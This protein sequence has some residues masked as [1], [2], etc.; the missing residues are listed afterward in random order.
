MERKLQERMV[1]AGVLV[2]V[3]VVIGPLLL[4]GG[5][6]REVDP[7]AIP[8]QRSDELH[9]QTIDLRA[10]GASR[11]PAAVAPAVAVPPPPPVP[12]E[13]PLAEPPPSAAAAPAPAVAAPVPTPAALPA[14]AAGQ[15]AKEAVAAAAPATAAERVTQPAASA[16]RPA[17]GGAWLVQVGTFSQK[18]NAERLVA[19]LRARGFA[20][21][22]SASGSGGRTLYR[23]RV[24]PAGSREAATTLAGRLAAAGHP[25]HVVAQ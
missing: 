23:V 17:A 1:G 19:E 15:P 8:G 20:A 9:T 10:T 24:G 16:A 3:L 14:P 5:P 7:Q 13:Q 2:L 18:D 4:D 6:Q 21:V 22:P 12:A 11:P 25:G